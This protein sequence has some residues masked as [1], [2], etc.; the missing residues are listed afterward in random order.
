M[1]LQGNLIIV[2][3][4]Y[5]KVKIYDKHYR[6][7]DILFMVL[8]QIMWL[9]TSEG[10]ILIYL[11]IKNDSKSFL[12]TQTITELINCKRLYHINCGRTQKLLTF[13]IAIYFNLW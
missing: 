5:K 1:D 11:V 4:Y 10:Q 9:N 12:L 8:P 13:T 6:M 7:S 2:Q 3:I